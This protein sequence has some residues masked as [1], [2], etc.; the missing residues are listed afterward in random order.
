MTRR[1]RSPVKKKA[2][3]R[4]KPVAEAPAGPTVAQK[5][6]PLRQ[7]FFVIIENLMAQTLEVSVLDESGSVTGLR[8][9]PRGKSHP[10]KHDRVG[11]YT[12]DLVKQGR[13]RIVQTN[14]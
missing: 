13:V 1:Q 4:K 8:L 10:I 5:A 2:T 3:A 9:G 11:T 7:Q 12:Q 6:P 14:G